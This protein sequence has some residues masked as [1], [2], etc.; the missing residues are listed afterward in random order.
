M[1]LYNLLS[2]SGLESF[3]L[4]FHLELFIYEEGGFRLWFRWFD[5]CGTRYRIP[6]QISTVICIRVRICIRP[7]VKQR[8]Q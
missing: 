7:V 1:I 6:K 8:F 4:S 2:V 3:G 5:V